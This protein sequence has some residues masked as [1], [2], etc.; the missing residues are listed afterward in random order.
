[1]IYV[2]TSLGCVARQTTT[3]NNTVA[4]IASVTLTVHGTFISPIAAIKWLYE[5]NNLVDS[6]A[7]GMPSL[8][9]YTYIYVYIYIFIIH[10]IF[11]L[12]LDQSKHVTWA[13]IPQLKL[14]NIRGFRCTPF[15]LTFK[16]L[17]NSLISQYLHFSFHRHFKSGFAAPHLCIHT[18]FLHY[19]DPLNTEEVN[20][21]SDLK[22]AH[23][24]C[25]CRQLQS[26]LDRPLI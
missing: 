7:S 22:T 21:A 4:N 25:C 17:S 23:T 5:P 3:R 15:F 26:S 6:F 11:S 14:G 12:T 24:T 19:H 18:K 9:I 10:Q 8:Y 13:N 20:I 16:G 2:I 1:M